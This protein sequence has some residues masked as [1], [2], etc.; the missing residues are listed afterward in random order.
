MNKTSL[1]AFLSVLALFST[2][3]SFAE[4]AKP[5]VATATVEAKAEEKKE[6]KK[7]E[8]KEEAKEGEKKEEAKH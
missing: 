2:N 7:E 6:D 5:A 8:A 1:F 3:S 4:E